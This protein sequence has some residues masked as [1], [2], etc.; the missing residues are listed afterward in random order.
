M[1]IRSNQLTLNEAS[2]I[3]DNGVYLTETESALNPV[4][5]PV[6]ENQR[7]GICTV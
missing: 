7:L 5:V 3:L 6:L 4:A 1:L 2:S